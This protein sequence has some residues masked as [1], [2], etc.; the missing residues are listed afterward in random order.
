[1]RSWS[2][3]TKLGEVCFT[4]RDLQS[5]RVLAALNCTRKVMWC[6]RPVTLFRGQ[7]ADSRL[8]GNSQKSRGLDSSN[9]RSR[10]RC[11]VVRAKPSLSRRALG[12]PSSGCALVCER[13]NIPYPTATIKLHLPGRLPPVWA[14]GG[15]E[16]PNAPLRT[17][18]IAKSCFD[19]CTRLP[20]RNDGPHCI[21]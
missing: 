3:E 15:R 6:K 7:H 13:R 8:S 19:D 9:D 21:G 18:G 16:Q 20:H 11:W 10:C 14:K 17:W 5:S 2:V 1:V 4:I 12:T